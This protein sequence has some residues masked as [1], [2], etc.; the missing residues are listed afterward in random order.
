MGTHGRHNHLLLLLA[1]KSQR[2]V[3][4]LGISS[5]H[6]CPVQFQAMVGQAGSDVVVWA[7]KPLN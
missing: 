1:A 6:V 4:Q 2:I 3:K 7:C 5:H